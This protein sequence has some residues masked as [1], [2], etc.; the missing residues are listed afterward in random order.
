MKTA[1]FILII[2]VLF[3]N[4]TNIDN[5]IYQSTDIGIKA[6]AFAKEVLKENLRSDTLQLESHPKES[7]FFEI[8]S[9]ENLQT[10]ITY[11]NKNYPKKSRPRYYEHFTLIVFKY[12]NSGAASRSFDQLVKNSKYG[13]RDLQSLDEQQAEKTEKIA[14]YAKYGGLITQQDNL[15]LALVETCQSTPIGGNWKDYEDKFL[16]KIS[17]NDMELEVLNANCGMDRFILEKRKTKNR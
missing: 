2:F 12:L 3:T 4:E 6:H 7:Q 14:T 10:I 11:S 5:P 1:T 13:V 16:S 9:H 17:N 8:F 15:I